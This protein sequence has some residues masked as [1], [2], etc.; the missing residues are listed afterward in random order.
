[1]YS[2]YISF[3]ILDRPTQR[4]FTGKYTL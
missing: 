4:T 3:N 1:M 2:V